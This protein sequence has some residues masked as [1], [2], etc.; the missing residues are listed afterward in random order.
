MSSNDNEV[1]KNGL[2]SELPGSSVVRTL[3][4]EEET[5]IPQALQCN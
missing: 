3:T 5:K 1:V 4:T 2:V